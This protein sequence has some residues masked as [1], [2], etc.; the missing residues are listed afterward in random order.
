VT[1]VHLSRHRVIT[2]YREPTEPSPCGT[3]RIDQ[4]KQFVTTL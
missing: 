2:I 3:Q 4:P 1:D